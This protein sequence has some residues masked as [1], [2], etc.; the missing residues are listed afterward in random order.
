MV[1]EMGRKQPAQRPT[2]AQDGA[3][4]N[5]RARTISTY[6]ALAGVSTDRARMLPNRLTRLR[7]S[8]KW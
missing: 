1:G 2:L 8:V 5:Y 6:R 3:F 4:L 7:P